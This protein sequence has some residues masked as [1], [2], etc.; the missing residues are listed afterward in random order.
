M[1][2]KRDYYE[3]LGV[4]KTA[5]ADELKK[6]YR[7]KAMMYHPDKNPGDKVAEE[8]FKEVNE[9]YE[10]LSDEKKRSTYDQYGHD[11]MDS[12]FGG[13]TGHYSYGGGFG[14]FEDILS[15]LFGGMGGGFG[16]FGGFGGG[17]RRGPRR[18]SD[19]K[20]SLNLTF[21]EAI[22]GTEKKIKIKRKEGCHECD[23]SGAKPGSGTKTCD[24][25]GGR[26]Q[27]NIRQQTPFGI[28][29]QTTVCDK[30]GGEGTVVEN[31]C[32]TCNGTGIEEKERTISV[33]IPAGVDN[34]SILPLRGEG[35]KGAK[36]GAQGDLL[37]YMNVKDDEVF[38]REG[39]DIY[40]E[41]PIT[42]AQAVLG[43]DITIPT[44]EG[45]V[46]LKVPEGT[47]SHKIFRL[48]GKGV[49]NVNGYGRGDQYV[50]VTIETPKKLNKEQKNLLKQFDSAMGQN[51]HEKNNS[52][53]EKVKNVLG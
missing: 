4:A 25:C 16:G 38:E 41:M 49:Q 14:G 33:K 5:T 42:Y 34:N 21:K 11:G 1:S 48:R 47:Q 19:M 29:Q 39:D 43:A 17:G 28:V 6:A 50:T 26:G 45:K 31:P 7:K 30:C 36:G 13:G 27:V 20:I 53:W 15:D 12:A 44:I 10:V 24:K 8:K 18:G 40:L 23:G 37:V 46:K 2:E 22:F 52:F 35:N 3:V 51:N 32:G 9:A